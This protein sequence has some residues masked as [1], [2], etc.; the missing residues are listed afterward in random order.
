VAVSGGEFEFARL[1]GVQADAALRGVSCESPA[2]MRADTSE[3]TFV[4]GVTGPGRTCEVLLA[5]WRNI[6]PTDTVVAVKIAAPDE[7]GGQ[8]VGLTSESGSMS[9]SASAVWLQP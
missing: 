5:Q 4:F 3:G 9:F 8:Q 2:R 6:S 1:D 7:R